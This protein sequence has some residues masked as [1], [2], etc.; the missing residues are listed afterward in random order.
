MLYGY[1]VF[2]LVDWK[3]VAGLTRTTFRE[4]EVE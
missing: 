4:G 2:Q 1:E 3:D